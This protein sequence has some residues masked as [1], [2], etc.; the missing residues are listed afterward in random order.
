MREAEHNEERM[1]EGYPPR[2]Y[3]EPSIEQ[4]TEKWI[5]EFRPTPEWEEHLRQY[6]Q[7][8]SDLFPGEVE[9]IKERDSRSAKAK[10]RRKE[11]RRVDIPYIFQAGKMVAAMTVPGLHKCRFRPK[12]MVQ[13][14]NRST[15]PLG[16]DETLRQFAETL[17]L[18]V[19]GYRSLEIQR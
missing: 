19:R 18:V 4:Y 11:N 6:E 14:L 9:R 15:P 12:P 10:R 13:P 5:D 17:T 7:D 16:R 2:P 3:V 8:K 1:S